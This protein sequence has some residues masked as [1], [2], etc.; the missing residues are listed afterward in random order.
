MAAVCQPRRERR[1]RAPCSPAR[2]TVRR[3]LA[4]VRPAGERPL[5]S[6]EAGSRIAEYFGRIPR[7]TGV[8]RELRIATHRLLRPEFRLLFGR[9]S[10]K[11]FQQSVSQPRSRLSVELHRRRF[12]FFLCHSSILPHVSSSIEESR[13]SP[14]GPSGC[15]LPASPIPAGAWSGRANAAFSALS[16]SRAPSW[17]PA[18]CT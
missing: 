18:T 7:H 12:D 13:R 11:T 8:S 15:W 3:R 1:C 5:D 10:L 4:R 14:A 9:R 17:C 16:R 6:R 2:S